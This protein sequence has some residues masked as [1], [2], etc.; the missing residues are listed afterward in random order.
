MD[1]DKDSVKDFVAMF[2]TK[3]EFRWPHEEHHPH[4]FKQFKKSLKKNP[5]WRLRKRLW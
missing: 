1:R 3:E 5:S 2:L 4:D